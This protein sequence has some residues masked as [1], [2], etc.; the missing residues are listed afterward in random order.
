M[1][2]LSNPFLSVPGYIH[3]TSTAE[4]DIEIAVTVLNR[5]WR[6]TRSPILRA[7]RHRLKVQ[8]KFA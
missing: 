7:D 4:I 2:Y 8:A 6:S 5:A 1:S 3:Y